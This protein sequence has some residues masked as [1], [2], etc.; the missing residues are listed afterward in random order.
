[1]LLLEAADAITSFLEAGEAT[2][3]FVPFLA[4]ALRVTLAADRAPARETGLYVR[5]ILWDVI[6]LTF[7]GMC[8]TVWPMEDFFSGCLLICAAALIFYCLGGLAL[9]FL[10][11]IF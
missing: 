11:A 8:A 5:T 3:F 7:C 4:R 10:G 6:D 1:M 9:S 2:R